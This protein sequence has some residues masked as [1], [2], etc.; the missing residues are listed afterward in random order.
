MAREGLLAFSP[1]GVL[2]AGAGVVLFL[3]AF[4]S[5]RP[6]VAF[7]AVALLAFQF[8]ARHVHESSPVQVT[9]HLPANAHLGQR[10]RIITTATTD[11]PLLLTVHSR[12]P[13]SFQEQSMK[14][15][16]GRHRTQQ[17]LT[18][19]P[20]APG[21][22][23]WPRIDVETSDR[24]GLWQKTHPVTSEQETHVTPEP[25]WSSEGSRTRSSTIAKL[26]VSR[27]AT[28]P[29]PVAHSVREFRAGD[30][31][32][33]IDWAHSTRGVGTF[34]RE[35]E[36]VML[37]PVV[38]LLDATR[39]MRWLRRTSKL[40]TASRIAV[41]VVA[42][43]RRAGA[44]TGLV[45]FTDDE[46]LSSM[47]PRGTIKGT[48]ERLARLPTHDDDP[49]D[50]QS[51][52]PPPVAAALQKARSLSGTP[53][54]IVAILDAEAAPRRTRSILERLGRQ[55]HDL[56]LVVPATGTHHYVRHEAKKGLLDNLRGYRMT[57]QEVERFCRA[58]QIP[59]LIAYPQEEQ[60][61]LTEVSGRRH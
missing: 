9:R 2:I 50:M 27:W 13:P 32:K 34:T 36:R 55:G 53:A 46:V 54:L 29:S 48:L 4:L 40:T 22:T 57:R 12:L 19:I 11:A 17:I 26:V 58:R 49:S 42:M 21:T 44:P 20:V 18:A 14:N 37:R 61:V 41:A 59:V 25:R 1:F 31:L 5:A 3:L 56:M 6:A 60:E 7:V 45:S 39:T 52:D 28:Q 35:S 24:W 23:R 43:V 30:R 16:A 10:V 15:P 51:E 8:A 47:G 33:D 38:L